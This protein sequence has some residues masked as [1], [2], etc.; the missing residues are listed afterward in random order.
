MR[1]NEGGAVASFAAFDLQLTK[2]NDKIDVKG[3]NMQFIEAFEE[4]IFYRGFDYYERKKV[5]SCKQ[6][7]KFTYDG[8]VSGTGNGKPYSVHIDLEEAMNSTCTCPYATKSEEKLLCKHMAALFFAAEPESASAYRPKADMYRKEVSNNASISRFVSALESMYVLCDFLKIANLDEQPEGFNMSIRDVLKQELVRMGT[9][10][11]SGGERPSE[12]AVSVLNKMLDTDFTAEEIETADRE[13]RI[14]DAYK[15]IP[16]EIDIAIKEDAEHTIMQLFEAFGKTLTEAAF[17]GREEYMRKVYT[18]LEYLQNCLVRTA[19]GSLREY[20][21]FGTEQYGKQ[22]TNKEKE[23]IAENKERTA[24]KERFDNG[25]K[26][27]Y[28]GMHSLAENAGES[29]NDY[30]E[31][32]AEL[33]GMIG[34]D[35]VK[36]EVRSLANLVRIGKIRQSRGL[37]QPERSLHMIFSGNPGTGKTTVAR[38]IARIYQALGVLS[39]GHLVET[40]RSGLVAGYVGQT[41]LKTAAVIEEAMG[42]VLFIDEAY[43]LANKGS[44]NDFGQEAIETILKAM[45]DKR[46]DL[47][48][49]AAGYTDLMEKFV[50]SNPGLRSRFTKTLFFEDYNGKQLYDI[51]RKMCRDSKMTVTAEADENMKVYFADLFENRDENFANARDVRNT[52]EKILA[53]Q[54]NRLAAAGEAELTDEM[55]MEICAEDTLL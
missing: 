26:S 35:N 18:Y 38:L 33:D 12:R 5:C 7:G 11:I 25:D 3:R 10:V 28:K 54:A 6:T 42:G 40:D 41:A 15:N 17:D 49:I 23:E 46:D 52:F 44:D 27:E 47:V 20:R 29:G 43:A 34:L 55:L 45:E 53:R 8:K 36:Q 51:F 22:D 31:L 4:K 50:S 37:E 13:N 14:K 32:L 16:L 1:A 24:N 48:V 30:N 19:Y 2:K 39:S 21:S 9:Y